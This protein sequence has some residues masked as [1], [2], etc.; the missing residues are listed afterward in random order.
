MRGLADQKYL[1]E[2]EGGQHV[3]RQENLEKAKESC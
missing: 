2:Q 3:Y 1:G